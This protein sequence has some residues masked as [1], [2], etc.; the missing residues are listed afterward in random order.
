[1][2]ELLQRS[3][4]DL[5]TL[6]AQCA[7]GAA[8]RRSDRTHPVRPRRC[9]RLVAIQRAGGYR[10]SVYG[11]HFPPR[12][13]S[14]IGHQRG[15]SIDG[16]LLVWLKLLAA[17]APD[18]HVV[19]VDESVDARQGFDACHGAEWDV[20]RAVASFLHQNNLPVA[21]LVGHSHDAFGHGSKPFGRDEHS[22]Q[23]IHCIRIHTRG[24]DDQVG[25]KRAECRYDDLV[26]CVQVAVVTGTGWEWN[27][28]VV[29][30]SAAVAALGDET[31][32]RGEAAVLMD[33]NCQHGRIFGEDGLRAVAVVY[34]PVQDR[35]L[36]DAQYFP[37]VGNGHCTVVE[38]AEP[39]TGL[40]RA[41]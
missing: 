2:A 35:D 24:D 41:W 3:I 4:A 25:S 15:S 13:W 5:G 12:R 10:R 7:I 29:A 1:M 39:H 31:R 16:Y 8:R 19:G 27:I 6:S 40:G 33:R 17:E 32:V 23:R 14:E 38:H 21:H 36:L 34:V 22:S 26:H 28:D 37:G 11:R 9:E 18:N 20:V 30:E